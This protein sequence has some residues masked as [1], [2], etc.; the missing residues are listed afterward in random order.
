MKLLKIERAAARIGITCGQVIELL[1]KNVITDGEIIDEEIYIPS[2]S[3]EYL[4]KHRDLLFNLQEL[5]GVQAVSLALKASPETINNWLRLKKLVPDRIY[6]GKNFFYRQT[7]ISLRDRLESED[8]NSLKSRRNKTFKTSNEFY[9]HYLL[10]YS[11]NRGEVSELLERFAEIRDE[12]KDGAMIS[13]LLAECALQL[14]NQRLGIWMCGSSDLLRS[15][16]A[17]KMDLLSMKPMIDDLIINREMALEIVNNC[18][19][20]FQSRYIYQSHEDLL[21]CLY[22]SLSSLSQRKTGGIYYTPQKVVG[23]LT[24]CLGDADMLGDG[25]RYFDPC[26]GTG[27][28]I[29]NLPSVISWDR[30]AAGDID[31]QAVLLCRINMFL[32]SPDIPVRELYRRIT[33]SDY[34]KASGDFNGI[35]ETGP[36]CILGN[37]PWGMRY[38]PEN[39]LEFS[40]VF[41]TASPANCESFCLFLE[42]SIMGTRTGDVI[43]FV[44]PE[45]ILQVFAHQPVRRLIARHC[46]IKSCNLIGLQFDGVSCPSL[47]LTVRREPENTDESLLRTRGAQ[48]VT[49]KKS[50]EIDSDR[51]FSGDFDLTMDNE[52][53]RLFNA[54]MSCPDV[55]SLKNQAQWAIGIVTGDNKGILKKEKSSRKCEMVLKGVNID[56]YRINH[57]NVSYLEFVPERFQQVAREEYY[58]AGEKLFYRFINRDLIFAYDCRRLLSLNSANI[59]IPQIPELGIKCVLMML[60]SRIARFIYQKKFAS[61]K[62]LRS[63]LESIPL[64]RLSDDERSKLTAM[65]D[66]LLDSHISKD[67]E[68]EI[69]NQ[70]DG[71]LC[72]I[73]GLSQEDTK[74]L[75][76]LID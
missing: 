72:S 39:R 76:Q 64:K 66:R 30:I 61:A 50:F 34:L 35:E 7:I 51:K 10:A 28:F 43:S 42:R 13:L 74:L 1:T 65:A 73:Y 36:L 37:P 41:R 75:F 40:R 62:V 59:L 53:Y 15:Y 26:C 49:L 21:G 16:L 47:I 11:P 14:L 12:I 3:V 29:I 33:V 5:F 8:G 56:R 54:I 63:H 4:G 70:A 17:G 27:N 68:E 67:E 6:Q 24:G 48:V 2:T 71:M 60:N 69:R 23:T 20:L 32:R 44:L 58:R 9:D 31:R 52:E 38:T 19:G 18:P 57:K 46:S 45:S 55:T 22:L 25:I